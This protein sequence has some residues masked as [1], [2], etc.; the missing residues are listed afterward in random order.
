MHSEFTSPKGQGGFRGPASPVETKGLWGPGSREWV[1][2]S[3]NAI[4]Q[5]LSPQKLLLSC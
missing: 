4:S 2:L 5:N 3:H 1:P